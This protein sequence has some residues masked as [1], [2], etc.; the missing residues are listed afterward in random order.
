MRYDVTPQSRRDFLR[1]SALGGVLS[2][3]FSASLAGTFPSE[4]IEKI[5][6]S[7]VS[8]VRSL[9]F[10]MSVEELK[11]DH[12][13]DYFGGGQGNPYPWVDFPICPVVIDGEYWVMYMTGDGPPVYRWKGTNIEN[14]RRQPDGSA[15]FPARRPYMLGGMWYDSGERKL[16][17]PMH[18]EYYEEGHRSPPERQIHLATSTDKGLTWHYEGP[19]VT[20]DSPAGPSRKPADF[21][22]VYWDGGAGDFFIYVDQQ[23]GYIYVYAGAYQWPKQGQQGS[24]FIRHQVARCAM[25]DKMMP[26]KWRKFYNGGWEEPGLGGKAS[27][28]NAYYVMYNSYLGKYIGMNY[29]SGI[30]VCSDL[31]KQDWTPTLKIKGDC[32]GCNGVWAWH[33]TDTN[34]VD[35]Y[36][37]G[38]TLFLYTYWKADGHQVPT[39]LYKIDLSRGQTSD[40]AGYSPESLFLD[41]VTCMEPTTFYPVEPIHDSPDRIENRHTRRVHCTSPEMCYSG[42]WSDEE[43]PQRIEIAVKASGTPDG[44]VQF[45]FQGADVYWRAVKGP[46]CGKA[47]VYID[48]LFQKTVDC[49]SDHNT[50]DQF[51][52]NK[53]G[54]DPKAAHTIKVVVRGDRS[55]LSKGTVIRHF[56]FEYS[57]E[58]YR[59]SDGFS[60]I[61]GKNG[62][63]YQQKDGSTYADMIFWNTKWV[64]DKCELGYYHSEIGH[65]HL[66]PGVSEVVRRWIAPHAG[67]V[68]IEGEVALAG[69]AGNGIYA[70]VLVNEKEVW[71]SRLIKGRDEQSHDVTLT[72]GNGDL[73]CFV[74]KRYGE[75][76]VERVT[77]DPVITYVGVLA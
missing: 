73:V 17:A 41:P 16:Y 45:S 25:S 20:R 59:A 32:W 8:G 67:S 36:S 23:G 76:P 14:G 57:A 69:S 33:L 24:S 6:S 53:T 64:G 28:V 27:Y 77:W 46:D 74:A 7:G 55:D 63:Y 58:S 2:R 61:M 30:A 26:G 50:A 70:M 62:W 13:P 11:F 72:V 51:A 19:I 71:A 40:Q 31:T 34:K 44:T 9:P 65:Y 68:R 22:G 10:R 75:E 12:Q 49:Y 66:I 42:R 15:P 18:C 48:G 35:I 52:F 47:D 21:S 4:R 54:L 1:T 60:G 5:S 38:Q 39:H 3:T 37:G 29:G 56:L 43:F